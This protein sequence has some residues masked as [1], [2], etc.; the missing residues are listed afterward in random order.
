VGNR[1]RLRKSPGGITWVDDCYNA[2]PRAVEALL[3]RF[4]RTPAEGRKVLVLGDMLEL[5]PFE[6]PAHRQAGE[7]ALGTVDLLV[8]VG[9]RAALAARAFADAGGTARECDTIE[10]VAAALRAYLR[11]G[12]WAAVKGSRG[13]RL[14]RLF[15]LME[16]VDAL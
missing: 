8:A 13:M 5:G 6:A 4:R 14:E 16:A 11:P 2:S 7:D 1:L 12:D 10:A 9:P 3:E 15:P